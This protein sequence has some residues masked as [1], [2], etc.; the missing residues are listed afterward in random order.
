MFRNNVWQAGGG[1]QLNLNNNRCLVA[2]QCVLF[3]HVQ[4]GLFILLMNHIYY[5]IIIPPNKMEYY[6][7]KKT[8]ML[9]SI[10][11]SVVGIDSIVIDNDN[12]AGSYHSGC[13]T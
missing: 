6:F 1:V 11:L 7:S 2:N 5:I 9:E 10:P 3:V 4:S 13:T 12:L 8:N